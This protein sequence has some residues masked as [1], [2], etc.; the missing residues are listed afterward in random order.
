MGITG[1]NYGIQPFQYKPSVAHKLKESLQT[2]SGGL[3]R[4]LRK[5]RSDQ[6]HILAVVKSLMFFI[7]Q[8][9]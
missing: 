2:A 7:P 1:R 9:C 4:I 8:G 6:F 5:P 3:I